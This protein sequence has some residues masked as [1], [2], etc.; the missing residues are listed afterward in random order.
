MTV[1]L[2]LLA[3]SSVAAGWLAV[4]ALFGPLGFHTFEQ[5]LA[6]LFEEDGSK[7]ESP[8]LLLIALSILA[9]LGG[10]WIAKKTYLKTWDGTLHR[11]LT[12]KWFMDDIYDFLFVNGLAKGGGRLLGAFDRNILDEGVNGAGWIARAMSKLWIWWDTWVVD[13][14]VRLTAFTFKVAGYPARMMQN[15]LIQSYALV[16]F[17]GV[18]ALL[19]Y[20]A[21][22]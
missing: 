19:G 13:G 8:E 2:Q 21:A 7:I 12:N 20:Y 11:M 6:P 5:W 3:L 9:A 18:L 4:P 10:W 15:G 1:P 22:R 17:A 14:A 16:F